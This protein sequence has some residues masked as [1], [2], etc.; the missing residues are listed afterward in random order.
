MNDSNNSMSIFTAGSF[1]GTKFPNFFRTFMG[2]VRLNIHILSAVRKSFKKNMIKFRG[3]N[4]QSFMKLRR[5]I[6]F[7]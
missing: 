2:I 1:D 4:Y 5:K 3:K 6:L 7:E